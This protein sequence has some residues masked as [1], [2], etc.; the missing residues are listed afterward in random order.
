[1]IRRSQAHRHGLSIAA[2]RTFVGPT[3][4]EF[5][6]AIKI[7]VHTL[8]NWKQGRRKRDGLLAGYIPP[9]IRSNCPDFQRGEVAERL[10]AAV[11]KISSGLCGFHKEF[12]GLAHL[13]AILDSRTLRSLGPTRAQ[14]K[15][16]ADISA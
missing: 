8:R 4:A 2:L 11:L 12:Q 1:M 13:L 16:R 15:P 7:S 5:A 6:D 3:Q 10:K 14:Q 9:E